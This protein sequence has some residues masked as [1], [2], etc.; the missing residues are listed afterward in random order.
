MAREDITQK[1]LT[2]ERLAEMVVNAIAW[3]P[4]SHYPAIEVGV[5]NGVV[6][7]SGSVPSP[8][9]KEAAEAA[10]KTVPDITL[11][12]NDLYVLPGDRDL[13]RAVE[14]ALD[15]D[16][17][18]DIRF[19]EVMA[20]DGAVTLRGEVTAPFEKLAALDDTYAVPGVERV[21]DEIEVL[22]SGEMTDHELEETVSA[23]IDRTAGRAKGVHAHVSKGTVY[24]FGTALSDYE[25]DQV[26]SAA[27]ST[28]G[29]ERVE[30][31]IKVA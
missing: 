1:E 7:L 17:R 31:R 9:E 8:R 30:S 16:A 21:V 27:E 14:A 23:V 28:P 15:N 25:R 22:P 2:D 12:V 10:A 20:N 26:K 4:G 13:M 5:E 29:V 18:V 24:L 3:R 19:F 6:T 11:V